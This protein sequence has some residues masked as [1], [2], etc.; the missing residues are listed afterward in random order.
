MGK[1]FYNI[2]P[3]SSSKARLAK[4]GNEYYSSQNI[5]LSKIQ[6]ENGTQQYLY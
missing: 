1:K 6:N 2:G 3:W 4:A 5:D